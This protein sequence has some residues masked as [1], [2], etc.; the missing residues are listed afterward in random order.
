MG[1][2]SVYGAVERHKGTITV[3]TK[4][5]EGSTFTLYLPLIEAA[6]KKT[7]TAVTKPSLSKGRACILVVDDTEAV[8]DIATDMLGDL[9][10]EVR[11][12]KDGKEAVEYYEKSWKDVD[13][14]LLD[15]IMP[16]MNGRDTFIAMRGINPDTKVI[17]CTGYDLNPEVQEILDAGVLALVHKPF[18]QSELSEKVA[19][20]LGG[21][22]VDDSGEEA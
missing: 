12:A 8:R 17:L 13:L 5:D 14:V 20:F 16:E 7:P 1:L 2:A 21:G 6:E 4:L 18:E 9:G 3:E 22:G 15:M 19:Q 10:Y 11:T